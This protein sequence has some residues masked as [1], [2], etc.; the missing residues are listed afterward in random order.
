MKLETILLSD[1]ERKFLFESSCLLT[2]AFN[3]DNN[4]LFCS[5]IKGSSVW[6]KLHPSTLWMTSFAKYYVEES[7][8]DY[9]KFTVNVKSLFSR[10]QW[11]GILFN[12]FV[13]NLLENQP[14]IRDDNSSKKK[15]N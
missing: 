6:K 15:G 2:D 1:E 13:M 7:R 9:K 11:D 5:L 14:F 8:E 4:A 12:T 10:S 3:E